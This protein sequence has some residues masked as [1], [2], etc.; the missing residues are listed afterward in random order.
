MIISGN[1]GIG[2]STPQRLLHLYTSVPEII[3][4]DT[5]QAADSQSWGIQNYQGS[6]NFRTVNDMVTAETG[7]GK[8][9]SLT[10]S[11]NA[12]FAGNVGI[13]TTSPSGALAV[14]GTIFSNAIIPNGPYTTNLASYD[15]GATG[16][17]WNALWAGALNIG[18]S[19]FSIKS[20]ASSNL[21][22]YTAASGGGTQALTVTSAG[23]VGV[24][25]TTPG[26][27]LS[28][29]DTGANTINISATATS[30]FGSGL[31]ILTG[32]F[33]V[34]GTCVS[35]GAASLT[36]TTGQL[37]YFSG[38]D[39]AVGTSTMFISSA[40]NVGIGT[41]TPQTKLSLNSN[42]T[43]S[44]DFGSNAASRPWFITNDVS[45]YGDF[46]IAT[47]NGK[48]YSPSLVRLTID[49]SG[50]VG[51][52]TASPAN[53]LDIGTGGGIHITS[54][55]P[56]STSMA[57]YNNAGTLTWN[58]VALATGGSSISGTTNY[59]PVF[60]GAAT[61][62]DSVIYQSGSN[63]GIGTTTPSST[64]PVSIT[65]GTLLVSPQTPAGLP[66]ATLS[67]HFASNTGSGLNLSIQKSNDGA[68]AV[69]LAFYKSR[70][71][72]AVPTIV[73]SGD[74]SMDLISYGYDGSVYNQLSTILSSADGTVSAGST[75]GRL[76][77]STTPSGSSSA[78]ERMRID[79]SGN[80]GIGTTTPT[81]I[82]GMTDTSSKLLNLDAGTARGVLAVQGTGAEFALADW[83]GTVDNRWLDL[84]VNGGKG[85]WRTLTDGKSLARNIMTMDL[86]TGNVGIGTTTPG[87]LLSLGDTGAN[88][89][90]ISATATSTFG[91][92]LNILTG[93]FA[94]NGTCVGG[95]G[96]SLPSGT[97][98]QTLSYVGTTLTATSTLTIAASGNVGIGT[99]SPW[100]KLAITQTGT[101]G[102][103]AFIVEDSASPDTTPFI[104]DQTGNV[105][106]GLTAPQTKL[107]I[108][109]NSPGTGEATFKGLLQIQDP[110]VDLSAAAGGLEFKSVAGG[111]GYGWKIGASY[112]G[113]GTPFVFLTRQE[114]ATWSEKMR[115]GEDGNVGIGTTTPWGLLSVNANGLAGGAP[116]FVVGSSTATN[117]IVTNA[118]KVGVGTASPSSLLQISSATFSALGSYLK[119]GRTN[120]GAGGAIQFFG[121]TISALVGLDNNGS[122]TLGTLAAAPIVFSTDATNND[123]TLS[124][125]RM[126]I[127]STGNV[128][129]G[130]TTPWG[131]LS[132]NP[133][134]I[135]GPAFVVGSSTATNFIVT[136]AGKVG[137]GT[138]NPTGAL[139]VGS[140]QIFAANGSE[141][142]PA[143]SFTSDV[144]TGIYYDSA[145]TFRVST[146]GVGRVFFSNLSNATR[147][148]F[149]VTG[150]GTQP[151]IF[152]SGA[153][154]IGTSYGQNNYS[155]YTHFLVSD[156]DPT[157]P[158]I[159]LIR[160]R[161]AITAET[162]VTGGD[163]L[164]IVGGSG[165][166]GS[167]GNFVTA[168][169]IVFDS[170]G[171]V[172]NTTTGLS[173]VIR[174][175]TRNTGGS[176]TERMTILNDGN[177]GI[178]TTSPATLLEVGGAAA[179]VT[180]DFYK[181]CS[182]FTSNAN[183][184]LAC[185]ASDERMK[186]N[187]ISLA[188]TTGLAAINA[189]RPVSFYWNPSADRVSGQQYG[190]IAQEVQG[191]L[192]DLVG[193]TSPTALTPGG[194]LTVNYEGLISPMILA[195]QELDARTS[196][197][198]N[199][200]T[201][202]VLTVDVAGNVGIG[203][204]TPNHTLTVAGDIG[205]I[206]FVNTSTRSAKT[207]ISYV[208]A[209]STDDMLNQL[210]NLKVATYRY[211]IEDQNDPLRL[212]FISEDAATIAPEILSPDGK[213]VDLYKLAT[214]T[215]SG[216][217][218]LAAK[219]DTMNTRVT[220]LEDRIFA[221]ESGAVSSA[222]GSPITLST[223]SLA[224]AFEGLGVLI[225]KGIAQFNTLVFRQ[226]V[227]S[228][229]ADGT[230]SAGSVTI[231][232]GNT[233]AQ[234]TNSL[235]LPSTKVFV[236]FNSQIT[237]SWW[238]SDKLAGS[239]RVVL[240]EAQASDV[241]F[242]YF[243]VQT[244]GQLATSTPPTNLG[245]SPPSG[246]DTT[247]PAITLLGDNPIRLSVGGVFVE[248]GITVV[249]DS[250]GAI[251][252]Y[253]TF[254]NGI[255]GEAS[256]ATID[257]G[258]ETTYIITYKATD[259]RGNFSTVMRSV[260][261]GSASGT[262]TDSTPASS[263]DT[264]LPVVTLT[265]GAAMELAVGDIF[266]DPGATATDDIDGDITTSIVVTGT[267][268]AATAGS[269]TLTYTA[270][271][272]AG[273]VGTASRLVSVVAS[274]TTSVTPAAGS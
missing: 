83:G 82:L 108:G 172:S 16:S 200:A 20:D 98:G 255:E 49:P 136:N 29:G 195:I 222:S 205:A 156:T 10:R 269:Y 160:A 220:S 144:N 5:A 226:L 161:G 7:L 123:D 229:D 261:V 168:A 107:T 44:W 233:V 19:T 274:S 75:P 192:P 22:I 211:T 131:Q 112:L 169:Q 227:A 206:A 240:S 143:Y 154:I 47:A 59:I 185:T 238:V 140:G 126:R 257:T 53:L 35:G 33:A 157:I 207:D 137:I 134:G 93:C 133:N 76:T 235:V 69:N 223:T 31:N 241:S 23:N 50:N 221:L 236:T 66:G 45:A 231:I 34:N 37:A 212:G 208:T 81:Q 271:D 96:G 91:S 106:I 4:Q 260:I 180:F 130:T 213:G 48:N 188:T 198:Q 219:F 94:V 100:G 77:F 43:I 152:G 24:G 187:I 273:N 121:N 176:M 27:L 72:I 55:T 110:Q 1:V 17:R 234:V 218:A 89:I 6:L 111:N 268:D 122:L 184:L 142:S 155:G 38:T 159:N 214:F 263:T 52:G 209:S 70:G 132:V 194:T 51:I 266:T 145:D 117:F 78:T 9:F 39:T 203:T 248:P 191:V 73:Q 65:S 135:T 103:P 270:T 182:G 114:S 57:L 11:G 149:H 210:V 162:P 244:E 119:V 84:F 74:A 99:T 63:I 56:G 230:S 88:T 148:F 158:T 21:G 46:A 18:T 259:Q 225:Q 141:S 258:S 101:D 85:T 138:S 64:Y 150:S 97:D 105:G 201:S 124:N 199:A 58:G 216:V 197:I 262:T 54:G 3:S 272:A 42:A 190:L 237:G 109:S 215:L 232:A 104:I 62:G 79:S 8:V 87:T 25:T 193:V 127:D 228:K 32:C 267:V 174:F 250:D 80:I 2:T 245:V 166:V 14:A 256:S 224:S 68:N 249:D 129:I 120:G 26:T 186:Q 196:F 146:G 173:G 95:G 40:G 139:T 183:G 118:G 175:S 147:G 189:L 179:N 163:D 264:T 86:T 251:N 128:G 115:I 171:T 170:T 202:T 102:T 12:I 67:A 253:I 181:S 28:L 30:T 247:P 60:T 177:I 113:S 61:L 13:G 90:N 151:S 41:T 217:Q 265:G 254:V 125:E 15:L 243:L 165:Y 92:G 252:S 167:T 242:D 239:F 71:T 204:S 246:S 178:G 164:G 36:G 116:Q 153:T